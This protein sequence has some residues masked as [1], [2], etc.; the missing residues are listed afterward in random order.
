MA[1][2]LAFF[3]IFLIGYRVLENKVENASVDIGETILGAL[4]IS[5]LFSHVILISFLPNGGKWLLTAQIMVWVCDSFAYFTGMTIGRK[6]FNRGFSSISP[7][8]SIEGSIG[9]TVFTIVSLYFLEKYFHLLNNGE[10]GM[11]NIIIIGIFISIIAQIGDLGESMFKRE[12]KVKDSGNILKGHGGI[13]DRFDSMLF[14]A[15]TVYYLLKF[16]VL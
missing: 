9:G 7:K 4:Y 6:I 3:V 1:G 8:K 10:L 12:F 13:L 16:I 15:P 2:L 11:S 14:V 5:I